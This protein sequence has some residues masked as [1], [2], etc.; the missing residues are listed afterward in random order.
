M[1]KEPCWF[2]LHAYSD[3]EGELTPDNDLGYHTV[4]WSCSG[5]RIMIGC[6]GT[7]PMRI[8]SGVWNQY[9]AHSPSYDGI[10]GQWQMLQYTIQSPV[11]SVVEN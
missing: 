10:S 4:G 9:S 6:G 3:L 2:C 1:S 5:H 7:E 8:L 11:L